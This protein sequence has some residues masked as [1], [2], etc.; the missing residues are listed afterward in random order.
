MLSPKLFLPLA[1]ALVLV[2]CAAPQAESPA[3]TEEDLVIQPAQ[4]VDQQAKEKVNNLFS[5]SPAA[6]QAQQKALANCMQEKGF[7]WTPQESP[8]SFD[9]RSLYQPPLLTPEDA[10]TYGYQTPSLELESAG[11]FPQS[12]E[13]MRAYGGDPEKGSVSVDGVSGA[14]AKDGCLATSYEKVF[15]SAEA[16]VLFTSGISNVP[17]PYVSEASLE[18]ASYKKALEEW[19]SCMKN[20]YQVDIATPD[21]A[22]IDTSMDSK[23]LAIYDANCREEANFETAVEEDLDAYLTTFLEEEAGLIDQITQAKRTAEENA[24]KILGG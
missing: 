2:S 8:Q 10:E 21:L 24:P 14:I 15:G 9:V 11:T 5:I 23:T 20:K 18:G 1:T 13:A 4:V 22:V 3:E 17:L 12:E 6:H 16:G 7:S 19:R